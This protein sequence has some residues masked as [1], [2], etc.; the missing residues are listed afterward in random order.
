MGYKSASLKSSKSRSTM[1]DHIM[2]TCRDNN[3][4]YLSNIYF[5]DGQNKQSNAVNGVLKMWPNVSDESKTDILRLMFEWFYSSKRRRYSRIM[6]ICEEFKYNKLYSN[7]LVLK[8]V[9]ARSVKNQL[10]KGGHPKDFGNDFQ[11]DIQDKLKITLNN[12][13]DHRLEHINDSSSTFEAYTLAIWVNH[14]STI[15]CRLIKVIIKP[16]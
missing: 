1:K 14:Q 13:K 9:A 4:Y 10:N 12:I 11:E 3:H 16:K 6:Y 5:P 2:K 7:K 8:C 15:K